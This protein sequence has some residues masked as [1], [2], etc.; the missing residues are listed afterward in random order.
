M[1]SAQPPSTMV[2][3]LQRFTLLLLAALVV[4]CLLW[5]LWLVPTGRGSLAL[6]VVPLLFCAPGLWRHRLYT[7]RW[8]SLLVWLYF[9]EGVVR[10]WSDKG[11]SQSLAFAEVVLSL[12]LFAAGTAYIRWRL[13]HPLVEAAT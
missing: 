9:I 12:G 5:E 2:L 1:T 7:Y 13:K 11:L 3:R 8:L 10:A 6:K 4:L